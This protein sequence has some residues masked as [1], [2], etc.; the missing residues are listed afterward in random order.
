MSEQKRHD[1]MFPRLA[2]DTNPVSRTSPDVHGPSQTNLALSACTFAS[3]IFRGR[4]RSVQYDAL[5][6]L[7]VKVRQNSMSAPCTCVHIASLFRL[8]SVG[9]IRRHVCAF[10]PTGSHKLMNNWKNVL[11]I[12]EVSFRWT[13]DSRVGSVDVC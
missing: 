9:S 8:S 13:S 2:K 3:F 1:A 4:L 11:R 6:Q 5:L 10:S 12:Q 7:F